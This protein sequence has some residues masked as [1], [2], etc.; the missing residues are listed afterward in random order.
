MGE[1]DHITSLERGLG[2]LETVGG[3]FK[4]LTLTEVATR[5]KLS[6][7][8]T[9]RFLNTL[10]AVGYIE[11][12]DSKRYIL[13][14]K[15]LSL[16][17][18]FLTISNLTKIARHHIDELSSMLQRTVNLAVLDGFEIV[19]L[20]RKEVTR[21]LKYD[22]GPGSRL[23]AYCSSA[24]KILLAGLDDE[25]L[26]SLIHQHQLL[27]VTPKTIT[28]NSLLLKEIKQTRERGYSICDRELSMDLYSMAVPLFN[29]QG[30]LV[31]AVNVTMG[32]GNDRNT[33]K[34]KVVKMLMQKGEEL[35]RMLGYQLPYPQFRNQLQ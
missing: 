13:T 16:G 12:D 31:A 4:P 3:S 24:G 7:T 33:S 17:F 2:I 19:Y 21:F 10:C 14:R 34:N 29:D 6:K 15:I 25:A 27:P 30:K 8:T 28:S 32:A 1:R 35:S 23:P 18:N 20:Y 5:A 26:E 11:R 9:Q 22:L